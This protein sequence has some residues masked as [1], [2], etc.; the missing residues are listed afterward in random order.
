MLSILIVEDHE[1]L[2]GLLVGDVGRLRPD[3]SVASC[4]SVEEELRPLAPGPSDLVPP[5]PHLP[6]AKGFDGPRRI[7]DATSAAVT[8]VS[9]CGSRRVKEQ[10]LALGAA[11]F[12]EKSGDIDEFYAALRQVLGAR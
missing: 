1:L 6:H 2:R 10:A 5:D 4:G 9:A 8:I 7:R 12:V 11:S 3:A